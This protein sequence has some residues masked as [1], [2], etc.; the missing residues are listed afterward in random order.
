MGL[1]FRN[2]AWNPLWVAIGYPRRG[3]EGGVDY[4]KKG[5]WQVPAFETVKV[6]TGWVGG[7]PW[8]FYAEAHNPL[9]RWGGDY[10]TQVPNNA[11]DLCWNV[12]VN[13]SSNEGFGRVDI[14]WEIM[15]YTIVLSTT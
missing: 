12:G 7:D 10:F 1:Y 9:T 13:P 3:C 8:F 4:A 11:F 5:W 14:S 6:W 15:D 2:E